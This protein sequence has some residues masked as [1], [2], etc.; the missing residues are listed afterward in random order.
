MANNS[1][2]LPP[3]TVS[4]VLRRSD[5]SDERSMIFVDKMAAEDATTSLEYSNTIKASKRRSRSIGE[6]ELKKAMTS[7]SSHPPLR[8]TTDNT[9]SHLDYPALNGILDDFKGELSQLDPVSGSSLVLR[10]PSTP[11]RRAPFQSKTD[12]SVLLTNNQEEYPDSS[13]RAHAASPTLTLQIPSHQID[14]LNDRTSAPSSPIVPPR[15]SSLQRSTSRPHSIASPRGITSR[16]PSSPLRSRSGPVLGP[17]SP[18]PRDN[19]R[20]RTL[21]RSTASSSEPSLIPTG[22]DGRI[23]E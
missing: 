15:R 23:C 3:I 13:P 14:D 8:S 9:P 4:P 19:T 5:D 22:D 12:G 6:A 11:S 21:H 16:H 1:K 17:S 10:D 2:P 20:L 18:T 7:A